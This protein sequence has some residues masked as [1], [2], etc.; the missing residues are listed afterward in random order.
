MKRLLQ[1]GALLPLSQSP[2]ARLC[3]RLGLYV[4]DEANL[5]THGMTPMGRL[6]QDPA[7]SNAFLSGS[8]AWWP[9]TSTTQIIIR[10]LGNESGYGRPDA[11]YRW[12]K[13]RIPAASQVRR[14]GA[15]LPRPPTSSAHVC[16]YP[17]GST[18]P[19]VPKWRWPSGSA[20][21]KSTRPLILCEYA[22]AMGNS[23][24]LCPLLAGISRS[25]RL[26]WVCL[27]LGRSGAGQTDR[28]WPPFLGLWWRFRRH[29]QRSPVLL[30]RPAVPGSHPIPPVL[31]PGVPSSPSF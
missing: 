30:Q 2:R 17:S 31:K 4:V 14:G 15:D 12:V 5:E 24:G 9:G 7:W 27:G 13:G 22:H 28:R 8:P 29:S 25:S 6:A 20:C 23:L 18:F 19:A 26:G 16:P 10:S 1:R 3:D 21:R 11:M